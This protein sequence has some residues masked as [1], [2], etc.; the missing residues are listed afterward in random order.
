MEEHNSG[1]A[2]RLIRFNLFVE[3]AARQTR[4]NAL[5]CL[6][7]F[8][9]SLTAESTFISMLNRRFGKEERVSSRDGIFPPL[10]KSI[11]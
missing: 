5:F 8:K 4:S 9:V 10:I 7:I 11:F 3:N 2:N 1:P 6:I